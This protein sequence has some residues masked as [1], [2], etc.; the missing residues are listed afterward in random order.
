MYVAKQ[1]VVDPDEENKVTRDS[2]E[3][4]NKD[5]KEIRARLTQSLEN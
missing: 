2:I 5:I 4:L 1:I 3:D